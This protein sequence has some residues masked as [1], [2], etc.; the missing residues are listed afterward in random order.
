[1]WTVV[2]ELVVGFAL[3]FIALVGMMAW[4]W[5]EVARVDEVREQVDRR[6]AKG[7]AE[8]EEEDAAKER[9]VDEAAEAIHEGRGDETAREKERDGDGGRD[10]RGEDGDRREDEDR[11]GEGD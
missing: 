1:M 9:E 10:D 11:P 4:A 5:H 8:D 7:R 3:T 2:S 6:L